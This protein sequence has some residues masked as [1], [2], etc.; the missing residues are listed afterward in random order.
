MPPAKKTKAPPARL[1]FDEADIAYK[2]IYKNMSI[3][4][5]REE[6]GLTVKGTPTEY[7]AFLRLV[8]SNIGTWNAEQA[9]YREDLRRATVNDVAPTLSIAIKTIA[10]HAMD[11]MQEASKHVKEYMQPTVG[12]DEKVNTN[13]IGFMKDATKCVLEL[14]K[15]L[16]VV[17]PAKEQTE[18]TQS[19][20]SFELVIQPLEPLED[21]TQ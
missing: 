17:A 15:A 7:K 8:Q 14:A 6:L 11:V 3:A 2:Y 13:A 16:E 20:T 1:Q 9:L 5:I 18:A 4:D 21:V 12:A 19:D 10:S